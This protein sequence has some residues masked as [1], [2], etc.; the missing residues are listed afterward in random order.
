MRNGSEN[1]PVVKSPCTLYFLVS[2]LLQKQYI[3]IYRA[4][5]EA[6]LFG[7]TEVIV[8]DLKTQIEKLKSIQDGK[9]VSRIQEEFEVSF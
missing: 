5:M 6:S 4:L 8:E 2:L 3:F 7:D 9:T 1:Y